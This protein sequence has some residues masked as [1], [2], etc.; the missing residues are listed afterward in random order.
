M[1]LETSGTV[2]PLTIGHQLAA[3]GRLDEARA[4]YLAA[5]NECQKELAAAYA[6][7]GVTYVQEGRLEQ[8]RGP[9]ERAAAIDPNRSDY[10][11]QLGAIYEWAEEYPAAAECWRRVLALAPGAAARPHIGLGWALQQQRKLDEA[12]DEF[13]K[14]AAIDP[15]SPEPPL[16]LGLLE[17]ERGNF[18]AAEAAFREALR[19]S[20]TCHM[21]LYWLANIHGARLPGEDLAAL[22]ARLD[23]PAT[24]TEPRTR[25]LFALGQVHDARGEYPQAA[26]LL[27]E[28]NALQNSRVA[29]ARGFDPADRVAVVDG[30]IRGFDRELFARLAGAGL[31][32]KTPIFVVGLP[33][34]GTT[35]VEQVLASHPSVQGAGEL[36]LGPRALDAL[37]AVVG[38]PIS[39][40]DCIPLLLPPHVRRLAEGYLEQLRSA[41]GD[42][43]EYI[44]D[45]LPEN[46][47][48]LGLLSILF[49]GCTIIHCR[50]DLRD[51][52]LSCWTADFRSVPWASDASQIGT[53]FRQYLRIMDHWRSALPQPIHEFDYEELVSDFENSARR[54][55]SAVG[56]D[57]DPRCAEFHRS[58]R[59]VHT[60][61]RVQVRQAPHTRSV[62]R[63]KHYEHELAD[64]FMALPMTK[65]RT[66]HQP[67]LAFPRGPSRSKA[68]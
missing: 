59:S 11:D 15:A 5:I 52:A 23:D 44:V 43:A 21:A 1:N 34:S 62:A 17:M 22:R 27:R 40:L 61:S 13:R 32:A 64:L 51:V 4:A 49:P 33:R 65:V 35:L 36:M 63:W 7:L 53:I 19:L 66:A 8:A 18:V 12:A 3:A 56:L 67:T 47:L 14:A 57:W 16:S 20:P 46:Y 50:R 29:I 68:G 45:K 26:R 58:T 31:D 42:K 30:L 9:L 2:R 10:W 48:L 39:S 37:P 28:A 25:I 41:G 38:R 24:G 54:L 55:V 6:G 60:G